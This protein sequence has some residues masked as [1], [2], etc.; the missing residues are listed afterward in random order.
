MERIF[1]GGYQAVGW[2]VCRGLEW[3]AF[4]RNGNT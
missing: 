2:C 3:N 4:L 1:E